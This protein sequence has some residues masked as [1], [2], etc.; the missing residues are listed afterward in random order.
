[1][2]RQN[3]FRKPSFLAM[4]ARKNSVAPPTDSGIKISNASSMPVLRNRTAW[5]G[6]AWLKYAV[7]ISPRHIFDF[8]DR[9]R[10]LVWVFGSVHS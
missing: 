1:M 7:V 8:D 3:S 4:Y 9:L 6:A 10:R 2:T 5:S